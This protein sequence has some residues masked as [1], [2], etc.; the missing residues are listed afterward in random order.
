MVITTLL[1]VLSE[2]DWFIVVHLWIIFVWM[3][4]Y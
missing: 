2:L 1:D 4:F 3:V